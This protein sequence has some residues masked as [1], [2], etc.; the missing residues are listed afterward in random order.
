MGKEALKYYPQEE[1]KQKPIEPGEER[2]EEIFSGVID[3]EDDQTKNGD[4]N[5]KVVVD[6]DATGPGAIDINTKERRRHQIMEELNQYR[7]DI[8]S[9]ISK[10]KIAKKS[11]KMSFVSLKII[12]KK[13][14]FDK[15]VDSLS[16]E[17][18]TELNEIIE[19]IR[20]I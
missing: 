10:E 17:E 20:N 11:G 12:E 3:K 5:I 7:A 8:Q 9:L 15:Y 13:E 18:K 19:E 16:S 4:R 6:Q 1:E 2:S 14:K